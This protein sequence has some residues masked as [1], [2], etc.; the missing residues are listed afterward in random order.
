MQRER[1]RIHLFVQVDRSRASQCQKRRVRHLRVGE[2]PISIQSETTSLLHR[3]R[4]AGHTTDPSARYRKSNPLATLADGDGPGITPAPEGSKSVETAGV[5]DAGPKRGPSALYLD[6]VK[7]ICWI[8]SCR[9]R[10][11]DE[12]R[13][14]GNKVAITRRNRESFALENYQS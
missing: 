10:Y 4:R 5:V 1:F 6:I 11:R 9:Q 2:G 12:R 8:L 14:S 7:W 13:G 3:V